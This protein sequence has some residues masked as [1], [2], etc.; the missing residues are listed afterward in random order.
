MLLNVAQ[1]PG[2]LNGLY[3][4]DYYWYL[5]SE[6][7]CKAFLAPL[8]SVINRL[9]LPCLDVGCGEGQLSD[10]VSVPYTGFDGSEEA[11]RRARAKHP[12]GEFH[13]GR[14]ESPSVAGK[15]GVIVFGGLLSVLVKP[16]MQ[17]DFVGLYKKYDPSYFI[18]YDLAALDTSNLDGK[19][20]LRQ[21]YEGRADLPGLSPEVKL[22][23]KIRVYQCS[24]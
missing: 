1:E 18:V 3:A 11:I 8:G 13:V 17:L 22:H 20:E 15:F 12:A 14:I 16:E 24:P 5:R 6:A 21:S 19:Y 4:A 9:G 7:F 2:E 23:R 10:F